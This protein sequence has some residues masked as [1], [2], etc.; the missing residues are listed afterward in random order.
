MS[1]GDHSY[2][3]QLAGRVSGS[4]RRFAVVVSRFNGHVTEPLQES[5]VR[6][7][8]EHGAAADHVELH[9]VPGAWELPQACSWL[10]RKH[11]HDAI[12]AFGCLIRG[13]TAHFDLIASEV[14]RGLGAVTHEHG[15][16][17]IFGVLTTE[18]EA[19]A[20]ERADPARGD[21]G[22][23]AAL[24][25]LEMADMYARFGRTRAGL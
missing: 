13:E 8:V 6:C 17:V 12:L 22:R 25:A 11:R 5:A 18:N 7:L 4:G 9:R 15:V 16:P 14:A 21:K 1:T 3:E 23:E 2:A 19:Q 24:A 20:A 10:A